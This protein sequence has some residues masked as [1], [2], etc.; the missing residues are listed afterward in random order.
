MLNLFKV[1]LNK[2]SVK[3]LCS[4]LGLDPSIINHLQQAQRPHLSTKQA[5]KLYNNLY[6]PKTSWIACCKCRYRQEYETRE[7]RT[8]CYL[9][10]E[11]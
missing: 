4:L 1:L 2:A 9:G 5:G 10:D 11:G 8:G 6:L 7:L 3:P